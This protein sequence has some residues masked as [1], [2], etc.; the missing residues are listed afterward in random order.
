MLPKELILPL[1]SSI[2]MV[3]II[4]DRKFININFENKKR[5]KNKGDLLSIEHYYEIT[6]L[7]IH[8]YI[9]LFLQIVYNKA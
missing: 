9:S 4:Y 5:N 2:A 8:Y 1:W 6:R 3:K 7:S